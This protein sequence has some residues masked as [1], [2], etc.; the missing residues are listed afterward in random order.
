[1]RCRVCHNLFN[2][3]TEEGIVEKHSFFWFSCTLC[4]QRARTK[5]RFHKR[6]KKGLSGFSATDW[7]CTLLE[8]HFRCAHCHENKPNLTLDHIQSLSVGG[9]HQTTNIQPLCLECHTVKSR[10]EN[11]Y[12]SKKKKEMNEKIKASNF[13]SGFISRTSRD[14]SGKQVFHHLSF[15]STGTTEFLSGRQ[16]LSS[17]ILQG[18]NSGSTREWFLSGQFLPTA[19]LDSEYEGVVSGSK[20]TYPQNLVQ[21]VR[22]PK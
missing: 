19:C 7:L 2:K 21:P 14:G 17:S 3:V 11:L 16:I 18:A 9:D 4:V 20:W 12:W 8:N 15:Q 1:M 6:R 22:N 13:V 5:V 10:I